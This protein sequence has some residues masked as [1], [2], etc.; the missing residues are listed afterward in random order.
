[1]EEFYSYATLT[2]GGVEGG[3]ERK[4]PKYKFCKIVAKCALSAAYAPC[5][6]KS[7]L[8]S[9]DYSPLTHQEPKQS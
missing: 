6:K 3:K 9:L 8:F 5:G 2:K 1:M 7:K 4:K